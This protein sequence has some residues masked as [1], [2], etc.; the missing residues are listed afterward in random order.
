MNSKKKKTG[1]R[2]SRTEYAVRL[3]VLL[4]LTSVLG[5]LVHSNSFEYGAYVGSPLL[6]AVSAVYALA[7]LFVLIRWTVGR[8]HDFEE[9][10]W[11]SLILLIPVANIFWF[12]I[13]LIT[14]GTIGDNR[15]GADPLH[16]LPYHINTH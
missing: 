15:Y 8:L 9:T 14:D 16:R 11:K 5:Y 7:C 3:A 13:I 10:G 4:V 6:T 12:I 1:L 2:L